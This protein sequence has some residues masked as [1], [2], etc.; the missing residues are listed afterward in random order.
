MGQLTLT[1]TTLTLE[2]QG[3][4]RRFALSEVADQPITRRQQKIVYENLPNA[5]TAL[6]TPPQTS[7]YSWHPRRMCGP[8][9]RVPNVCAF[10]HSAPIDLEV[11]L[12]LN[13][14]LALRKSLGQM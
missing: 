13:T 12:W 9:N 14:M 8:F 2:I 1:T 7:V 11:P 3:F 4:S 10:L 5:L 6:H